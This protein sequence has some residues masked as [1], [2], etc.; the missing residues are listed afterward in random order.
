MY[1]IC[2]TVS[3]LLTF[4][5]EFWDRPRDLRQTAIGRGVG[6]MLDHMVI[7]VYQQIG[8]LESADAQVWCGEKSAFQGLFPHIQVKVE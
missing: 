5:R 3:E 8:V 1:D 2:I 6:E 4:R 7:Q